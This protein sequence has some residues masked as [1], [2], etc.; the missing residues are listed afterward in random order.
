MKILLS[1]FILS[2]SWQALSCEPSSPKDINFHVD[3]E[4]GIRKFYSSKRLLDDRPSV[5]LSNCEATA[6]TNKFIMLGL[7]LENLVLNN[8]IMG[9][10]F[11][12]QEESVEC[13]MENNPF[14]RHETAQDR[15]AKLKQKREFFNRCIVLQVTEFNENTGLR[16]PENQPGC[17]VEKRSK[18]SY[19]FSGA[20]CFIQPYEKSKISIHIDVR[21]D[22]L[23]KNILGQKETILADYNA[24]LNTYISGDASGFSSDLTALSTTEVRFSIT[25]PKG[26]LPLS[27]DFG[28]ERPLWPTDWKGAD[29]FLGEVE[30]KSLGDLNDEISVPLVANTICER[31]CVG[32]LCSSPCD[33]AQPI[34][35]EFSLYEIVEGKREFLKL[36]HD[37][38]VSSSQ[39]QGLL[40]GM[41]VSVPKGVLEEGKIYE[42][43]ANFRE[44]ELDYSYFNGRVSRELRLRNNYIGPL[45]RAGQINMVPQ[46]SV[47]SPSEDVPSVPLIRSLSFENSELN[48]LSRA[49][50]TWQ[51]KLDNA[52]WP[53]FYSTMC[54][55][56]TGECKASG[57]GYVTLS[58][59]FDLTKT[60]ESSWKTNLLEGMRTSNIVKNES[61]GANDVAMVTCGDQ[62]DDNDDD[63]DFDWGDI[64]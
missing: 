52:F 47:I 33:F 16:V 15:F 20:Y 10:N 59:K 63:D 50:A 32:N 21:E 31:K 12:P 34:V 29:L 64:L 30:V 49:L 51:S 58:V 40:Y 13:R 19:D 46:I 1:L 17:N 38:S 22:C 39:Y 53:P 27:E 61:W 48:G 60:S 18:W 25:P 2:I 9:F 44:P 57:S 42:I 56:E 35:G 43:E 7:G 11:T 36:W 14:S 62:G 4:K 28:V 54:S 37:G 8:A 45:A 55:S 24:L 3:L 6:K 26:L 5:S 23:D 41:G